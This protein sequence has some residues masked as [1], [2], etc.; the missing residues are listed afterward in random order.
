MKKII[1]LLFL[2]LLPLICYL[3]YNLTEKKETY[4]LSIG[5]EIANIIEMSDKDNII[6]NNDFIEKDYRVIDVLNI[7]K[8]NQEKNK[9]DKSISLHQ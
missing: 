2:F 6:Y 3:I 5:D 7:L 1:L 9:D 8:Y 4:I